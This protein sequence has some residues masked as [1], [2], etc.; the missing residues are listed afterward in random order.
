MRTFR[1]A[2]LPL[3]LILATLAS[4][5]LN[6]PP[7]L[8]SLYTFPSPSP[9]CTPTF[10]MDNSVKY[11]IIVGDEWVDLVR[12]LAEWKSLKG[13]PAEIY[14]I[15][16]IYQNFM[17]EDNASKIRNFLKSLYVSKGVQWV[18]LVGDVDKIPIR[19]FT[20]G[21]NLIPSDY[22]YAAL[23]G[24]FD[25]DN[26]GRYGEPGEID[27]SPEIYVGR[28]P[29]S[30]TDELEAFINKTLTYERYLYTHSGE[31]TS[32]VLL[33]G[34]EINSFQDIQGWRAKQVTLKAFPQLPS[35]Y[36]LL[37]Y[38]SIRNFDNLTE[39]SF[40][41][42]VSEG[43][44]IVNICSHGSQTGLYIAQNSPPFLTSNTA[45][46]L[47]NGYRLPLFFISACLAGYIDGGTDSIAESLLKNSGGGAIAV[48]AST[49]TTFGG[50]TINDA[51][52]TFFDYTFFKVFFS[53]DQPFNQRP[54]YALYKAKEEYYKSYK[55][56]LENNVTY[57]Q[58]FLEYILLGDPELPVCFGPIKSL[59]LEVDNRLVPG[60][61]TTLR[62]SDGNAPINGAYVCIK[63]LN[64]Y[65]TYITDKN[66]EIRFPCPERG[67]YNVT[68]TKEGFSPFQTIIEV[69]APIKILIDEYHQQDRYLELWNNTSILRNTLNASLFY[70]EKLTSEITLETLRNFD[71]LVVY[72]PSQNYTK[73][74]IEAVLSFV[75]SGGSLLII[76]E[77]DPALASNANKL[78]SYFNVAFSTS[79]LS[80]TVIARCTKAPQTFRANE[81]LLEDPGK[82]E[83]GRPL[84][85]APSITQE[86]IIASCIEWHNG[87]V[88][89]V[90]DLDLWKNTSVTEK[91]NIQLFKSLCEWLAGDIAPAQFNIQIPSEAK[92]GETVSISITATHP[93]RIVNLTVIVISGQKTITKTSQEN[94]VCF[95]LDTTKLENKIVI[96][97]VATTENGKIYVSDAKSITIT[98]HR[99][100]LNLPLVVSQQVTWRIPLTITITAILVIMLFLLH[101]STQKRNNTKK[102]PPGQRQK[103]STTQ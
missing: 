19:Y 11:V 20:I 56:L 94:K 6:Q 58:L 64:Y 99:V 74:E 25:D 96:Y 85:V 16:F 77:N 26:D 42:K 3:F 47:S 80:G 84:L 34:G 27:W 75:Q 32:K 83:G 13:F 61:I 15:G 81:I 51:A 7:Q 30:S 98:E 5:V 95:Q 8:Y 73:D 37:T 54:G 50:D 60:R 66:G 89:F 35:G 52:D 82:V 70:F 65:H 31:W 93:Y 92:K 41:E 46:N 2:V 44:A 102:S 59:N 76:G 63:G 23:D 67:I 55:N 17:G 29:V 14:T 57:T 71:I 33:I 18:L 100:P 87:K 101:G 48:I 72:Y 90:A 40:M 91:D 28:I 9:P 97:A 12:P 69:G 79:S 103:I 21:N 43:V 68:V 36:T 4:P 24:S 62:V 88:A 53:A 1:K 38:D 39:Q 78:A 49:R 22:Y 86:Y 45:K 10:F